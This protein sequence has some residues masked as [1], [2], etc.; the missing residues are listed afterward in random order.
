M[1]TVQLLNDLS[2]N[3]FTNKHFYGVFPSDK[4]PKFV[5]KPCLIIVNNAT[6]K[7]NGEH[8]TCF[9]LSKNVSK[10][11][12]F[13]SLGMKP[14]LPAYQLFLKNNCKS[15]MTNIKRLQSSFSN[16][17]GEYCLVFLLFCSKN[18]SMSTFLKQFSSKN[19]DQNDKKIATLYKKHFKA[20]SN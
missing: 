14:Y 8:W 13:D 20:I 16:V 15:Y 3:K 18:V 11:Y 6:S 2:K 9:Y 19:F 12:Y 17:C 7:E 4:L 10:N 1:N 5:D